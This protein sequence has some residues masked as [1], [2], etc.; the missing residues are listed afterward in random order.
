VHF[1]VS[2][3]QNQQMQKII[4]KYKMYLQSLHMFRQLNCHPQGVSIKELHARTVY[5]YTIG[6]FTA[7]VF[8]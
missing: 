7:E 1:I 2:L 5:K 4:N 6:G 3:N 8:T